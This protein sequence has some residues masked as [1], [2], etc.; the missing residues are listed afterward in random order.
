MSIAE[1]SLSGVDS[2]VHDVLMAETRTLPVVAVTT[3]G[4][5]SES[6]VSP[7]ELD[8]A[9]EGRAQVALIATG[10]V[11]WQLTERL[12]DRLDVFGGA[13]RIW[14]PGLSAS[15][16]PYDHPLFLIFGAPGAEVAKQKVFASIAAWERSRVAASPGPTEAWPSVASAQPEAAPAPS[17]PTPGSTARGRQIVTVRVTEISGRK[18]VVDDS[19]TRG[20]IA[21]TDVRLEELALRLRPGQAVPAFRVAQPTSE[22]PARYSVQ[23]LQVGME[24]A[25]GARSQAKPTP[26]RRPGRPDVP[27]PGPDTAWPVIALHYQEGDTVEARVS[28][29]EKRYLL[30][31]LLPGAPAIVPAPEVDYQRVDLQHEY[32]VGDR[33]RVQIQTLDPSARRCSASIKRAWGQEVRPGIGLFRDEPRQEPATSAPRDGEREQLARQVA[34]LEARLAQAEAQRKMEKEQVAQIRREKKALEDRELHLRK[35]YGFE[36]PFATETDFLTAVRVEYALR[37][38][39]D[40]RARYPLRRMIVGREFLARAR[41]LAGVDPDKIVEVCTDVA[42]GRSH[43]IPGRDQH[44]L[45]A[46]DSGPPRFRAVDGARAWRCSLQTNTAGARRLHWWNLGGEPETIEFAS[47]GVHDDFGIPE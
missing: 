40:E 34:Q 41:S 47:V 33:V 6:W 38:N 13:L 23:G 10:E 5:S 20:V 26:A 9:L 21:Y 16:D 46:G 2:F 28:R 37:Y 45:H 25:A 32:A 4:R 14:W 35:R 12:P 44:P 7:E 22:G 29:V 17:K 19:G 18:I 31:E 1:I 42:S 11:T 15:A 27:T 24:V 30:V 43:E 39:E 8:R 36:N 3:R